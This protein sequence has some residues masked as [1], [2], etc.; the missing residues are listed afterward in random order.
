MVADGLQDPR[1]TARWHNIYLGSTVAFILTTILFA[2]LFG[3]YFDLNHKARNCPLVYNKTNGVVTEAQ[4]AAWVSD[5]NSGWTLT[6]PLWSDTVD[7][8]TCDVDPDPANVDGFKK[9]PVWIAP[10]DLVSL[11]PAMQGKWPADFMQIV[12]DEGKGCL[13]ED[14]VKVC[15]GRTDLELLWTGG[16]QTMNGQKHCHDPGPP[17]KLYTGW[18]GDLYCTDGNDG[19]DDTVCDKSR[20]GRYFFYNR[21]CKCTG[22]SAYSGFSADQMNEDC[23]YGDTAVSICEQHQCKC[24]KS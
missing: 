4:M 11:F 8:C 21:P 24:T 20:D 7:A 22:C 14:H 2:I 13:P 15:L 19:N 5:T 23:Q 10:C 6:S 17:L 12:D 9:T 3:V 18:D 1:K 16:T